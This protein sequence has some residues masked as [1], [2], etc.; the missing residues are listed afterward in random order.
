MDLPANIRALYPFASHWLETPAGRLH[1]VDEGA[2]EAVIMLHG[3]PTW[4]FFYRDV[5]KDLSAT[6]RCIAPDHIGCGL[7]DKPQ[8]WTYR[9]Q[10][11]IDNVKALVNELGLESFSL[12]VHDWGGAIGMGLAEAMPD[13]VKRI[14]VLNTAAF[15]S[16]RIP[17]RIALC[18]VPGFGEWIVRGFNA[19]AAPALTMASS[20]GLPADVKAGFIFPYN[21]WANRIATHRFVADIPLDATH[22]SYATLK[23]VE[24]GLAQFKDRPMLILW[25]QKDFCFNNHFLA[26]WRTRFPDAKVQLY[27]DCDHYVLEDAGAEAR[28]VI[29][30]FL[31]RD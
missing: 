4:S 31:R 23:R 24:E 1:Y 5:I 26:E 27:P 10:D 15:R 19:F 22:P 13:K 7:S 2:G 12:I 9:L 25:G 3:N 28:G 11:H 6:H 30:E 18:K 21:N 29:S 8:Q 16:Q 20:K 14:V 17:K